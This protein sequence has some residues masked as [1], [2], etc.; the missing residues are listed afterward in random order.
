MNARITNA[1]VVT[2]DDA[3]WVFRGELDVAAGRIAALGPALPP[4]T[5]GTEIVDADGA[6]VL[7]GFV[8]G[9][10]HA[11]HVL[12][13]GRAEGIG[14]PRMARGPLGPIV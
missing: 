11:Y 9:H 10:V 6:I 7:P 4:P 12:M 14:S 1:L 2:M 13:R 8:N 5:T 3:G